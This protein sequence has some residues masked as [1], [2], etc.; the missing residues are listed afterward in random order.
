MEFR[1]SRARD[2]HATDAGDQVRD[3]AVPDL[4]SAVNSGVGE[5]AASRAANYRAHACA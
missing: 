5:I 4:I 1:R 3:R 2:R